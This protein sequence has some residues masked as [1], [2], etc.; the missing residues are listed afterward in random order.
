M[1]NKN[2]NREAAHNG[3][4]PASDQP[5]AQRCPSEAPGPITRSAYSAGPSRRAA[6]ARNPRG[7]L[8]TRRGPRGEHPPLRAFRARF[9]AVRGSRSSAIKQVRERRK[10]FGGLPDNAARTLRQCRALAPQKRR[11]PAQFGGLRRKR[12]A[13]GIPPAGLSRRYRKRPPRARRPALPQPCA[14]VLSAKAGLTA[15]FGMGPGDPRLCGRARGG[16]SPAAL[17]WSLPGSPSGAT[18][19]AAWRARIEDHASRSVLFIEDAKSSGY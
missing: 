13:G 8:R 9:A 6:P 4:K 10:P 15:G 11:V 19:A 14:A 7:G 5:I 17:I 18:L 1:T 12:P 2:P 16:R 3:R